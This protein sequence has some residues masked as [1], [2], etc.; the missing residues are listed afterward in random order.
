MPGGRST[1]S[2]ATPSSNGGMKSLCI[3][4]IAIPLTTTAATAATR[5]GFGI[6]RLRPM[7]LAASHFSPRSTKL[8]FSRRVTREL[9][10]SQ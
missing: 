9:G 5:T 8:S 4:D 1:L 3:R 10:R 2:C 7:T 6:R